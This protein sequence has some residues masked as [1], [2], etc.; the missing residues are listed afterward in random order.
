MSENTF[1]K[2]FSLPLELLGINDKFM[3]FYMFFH[4]FS[5]EKLMGYSVSLIMEIDE[6][7]DKGYTKEEIIKIIN[8][9]DFTTNDPELTKEEA[10][11]LKIYSLRALNIRYKLYIEEK[12]KEHSKEGF[13]KKRKH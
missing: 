13:T 1:Y 11:Y 4:I 2:L 9:C 5:D 12:E 6:L 3:D 8:E 10:E 7:L